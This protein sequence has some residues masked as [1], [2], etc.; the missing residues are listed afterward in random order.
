[1]LLSS[2]WFEGTGV[3]TWE[4]PESLR[5]L[6][7]PT[8]NVV[9]SGQVEMVPVPAGLLMATMSEPMKLGLNTLTPMMMKCRLSPIFG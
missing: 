7:I 6:S 9:A 2:I 1:M 5:L 4:P 8:L 3:N